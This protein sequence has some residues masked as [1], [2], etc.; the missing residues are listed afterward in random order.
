MFPLQPVEKIDLDGFKSLTDAGAQSGPWSGEESLGL[1]LKLRGQEVKLKVRL[2]LP[3]PL[4]SRHSCPVPAGQSQPRV[5][6]AS[7]CWLCPQRCGCFSG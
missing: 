5:Y 2:L 1:S 7:A 4:C 3:L 6:V